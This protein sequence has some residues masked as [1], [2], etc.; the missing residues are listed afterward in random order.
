MTTDAALLPA[1]ALDGPFLG[2]VKRLTDETRSSAIAKSRRDGVVRVWPEG[3]DGD[4][5]ADTQA[6]GGPQQALHVLPSEHLDRLKAEFPAAA[7]LHPGGLGE[8]FSSHGISE[9]TVCIGDIFAL[10]TARVQISQP[11]TPCWKIDSRC[12][13]EGMAAFIANHGC[14]GWYY[15]VLEAGDYRSG[16]ALI[17]LQRLPVAISLAR[18]HRTL[19]T[20]RPGL[21]AL[22][23]MATAPGLS[24]EWEAK[25]RKRMRWLLD[26][27]AA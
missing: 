14:A 13:V 17:H 24:P 7:N 21:Q 23:R 8:N 16:D 6:H 5:H 4:E 25:I 1:I 27:D 9:E 22:E 3:L 10:G 12:G 18:F 19:A 11:R 26:N 2:G 20:H 15:R